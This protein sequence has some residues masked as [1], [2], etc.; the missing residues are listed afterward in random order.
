MFAIRHTDILDIVNCGLVQPLQDRHSHHPRQYCQSFPFSCG[1]QDH[2]L[3]ILL[4]GQTLQ[5]TWHSRDADRY[6]DMGKKI[7]SLGLLCSCQS[8]GKRRVSWPV[9]CPHKSGCRFLGDWELL[10]G[11]GGSGP[12]I[13]HLLTKVAQ[14]PKACPRLWSSHHN[15]VCANCRQVTQ[16][17]CS[18][19]CMPEAGVDQHLMFLVPLIGAARH[20]LSNACS[21]TILTA[22]PCAQ[23]P[24]SKD[25]LQLVW[26]QESSENLARRD[27][28]HEICWLWQMLAPTDPR[29]M[30]SMQGEWRHLAAALCR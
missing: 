16:C 13:L 8:L 3:S 28:L 20:A 5:E 2:L 11:K 22:P 23:S 9:A 21:D 17:Q 24:E 14:I 19:A 4:T 12:G 30:L 26:A 7:L 18:R 15:H 6:L 25:E 1:P 27:S 29:M 10:K